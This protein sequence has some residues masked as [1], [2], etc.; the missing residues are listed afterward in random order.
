MAGVEE[1]VR[2]PAELRRVIDGDT[3]D[4]L[5]NWKRRT[6]WR[7]AVVTRVRLRDYSARERHQEA[8][9]GADGELVR[10]DGE[11]AL[12]VADLAL[13]GAEAIHVDMQGKD[14]LGRDVCW[15]WCDNESLGEILLEQKAVVAGRKEG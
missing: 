3:Y 9:Y 1:V 15:I 2:P 11:S 7:G 6:D 8:E 13:R 12:A 5:V 4:L 10:L 14:S